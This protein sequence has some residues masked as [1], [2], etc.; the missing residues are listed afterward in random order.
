MI[1]AI[2]MLMTL[3]TKRMK[4]KNF[5]QNGGLQLQEFMRSRGR[6][7]AFIRIFTESE[8]KVATNN[9]ADDM[10]I[11]AGG[12]G[13]VY[14]G[15]LET[16]Q[17]VAVKKAL[18]L[19]DEDNKEFLNE[20]NILT[21]IHH[22]HIVKLLG[23]CLETKT[24]LLVYEYASNGTLGDHLQE[25]SKNGY[26]M[27]WDR[28][29]LVAIQTAEALSYLHCSASPPILHRDVKSTNILLD[30]QWNA[31]VGDFG[32]SR[33]VPNGE[34]HIS[35]VVQGTLGYLDPEYF[36]TLQ[37]TDKSD[38]YSM[39]V[40]LVELITSLKPVDSHH[41]DPR[42]SNLALLFL[43]HV[44]EEKLDEII[45]PRLEMVDNSV[46]IKSSMLVVASLAHRCLALMGH[47]RPSMIEVEH[48]LH[49]ILRKL[50]ASEAKDLATHLQFSGAVTMENGECVIHSDSSQWKGDSQIYGISSDLLR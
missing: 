46:S 20:L 17:L 31:K 22:K 47:D 4:R 11:G 37:L 28:R 44:K 43:H 33:L 7:N 36:Q 30:D 6:E 26:L 49:E 8:M 10:K 14:K 1:F 16:G 40:V 2:I 42:F 5:V 19:E 18:V 35:T 48:E 50:H 3:W 27:G 21:Q 24:P 29:L 45:D 12:F 13:A 34:Q 23:C 15:K 39:G 25:T 41:R 32:V 9:Y 38:V